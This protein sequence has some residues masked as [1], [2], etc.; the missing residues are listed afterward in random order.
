MAIYEPLL[1]VGEQRLWR[2]VS[3]KSLRVSEFLHPRVFDD[4]KDELHSILP[5]CLVGSAVGSL[6]F[7]R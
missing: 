4:S 2:D 1:E 5:R 3:V 6:G 7:V